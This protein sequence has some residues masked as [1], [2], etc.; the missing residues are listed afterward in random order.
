MKEA[1]MGNFLIV[2]VCAL[3]VVVV[4]VFSW[5]RAARNG[6]EILTRHNP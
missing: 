2:C 4:V 3:V 5:G 1:N 6:D